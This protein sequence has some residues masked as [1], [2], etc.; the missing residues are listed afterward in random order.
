MSSSPVL[1][2]PIAG[3]ALALF[4][5]GLAVGVSFLATPVKFLAPSLSLPVALD[6]GR[7]TFAFFNRAEWVL[8]ATLLAVL[9]AGPRSRIAIGGAVLVAALVLLEAL[10]MLPA[11]DARVGMIMAGQPVPPSMLHNAYIGAELVKLALLVVVAVAL[12]RQ[13]ARQLRLP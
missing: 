11:L 10:W 5:V 2:T 3:F 9:L 4:W 12:G 7:Q 6:V 13:I 1:R 8:A